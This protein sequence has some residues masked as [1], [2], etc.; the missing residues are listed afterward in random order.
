MLKF[1][2]MTAAV[3]MV[4]PVTTHAMA[5]K[6]PKNQSV[7]GVDRP[8]S[9]KPKPEIRSESPACKEAKAYAMGLRSGALKSL[10]S[11]AQRASS[12]ATQLEINFFNCRQG[13]AQE[14]ISVAEISV[15]GGYLSQDQ[16]KQKVEANLKVCDE[17]RASE[18]SGLVGTVKSMPAILTTPDY[19][20]PASTAPSAVPAVSKPASAS[21]IK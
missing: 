9:P 16:L 18:K 1:A 17:N 2:V 3:L 12:D 5:K 14:A 21:S 6:T 4:L 19:R 11:A 8:V 7:G 10:N 13:Y 15:C 20:T